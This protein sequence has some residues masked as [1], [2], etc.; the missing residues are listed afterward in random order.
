MRHTT[1]GG[2]RAGEG[3]RLDVL[4][5]V[6]LPSSILRCAGAIVYGDGKTGPEKLTTICGIPGAMT[7]ARSASRRTQ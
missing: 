5:R 6:F 1:Y 7:S 4:G 3:R 2:R